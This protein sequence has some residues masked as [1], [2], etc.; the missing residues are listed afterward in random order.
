MPATSL[1]APS[2][3]YHS[4]GWDH[5]GPAY[6]GLPGSQAKPAGWAR[7]GE[8]RR[9]LAVCYLRTQNT[10]F[11]LKNWT[12]CLK[13]GIWGIKLDFFC[14]WTQKL[15]RSE[16]NSKCNEGSYMCQVFFFPVWNP[17]CFLTS[18]YWLK[19]FLMLYFCSRMKEARSC[20]IGKTQG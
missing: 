10:P 8:K 1:F 17:Y 14:A 7:Q 5:K 9:P 3:S 6:Q 18:T 12:L 15:C 2:P 20:R 19:H 16:R 11:T 4:R 13:I